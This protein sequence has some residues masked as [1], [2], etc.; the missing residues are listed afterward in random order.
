MGV[1]I[2][3]GWGAVNFL[4]LMGRRTGSGQR[5]QFR[6]IRKLFFFQGGEGDSIS[7]AFLCAG[8][9]RAFAHKNRKLK[10]KAPSGV[11]GVSKVYR[12][13]DVMVASCLHLENGG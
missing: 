10:E 11:G 8:P 2:T 9:L 12:D 5:A 3:A 6:K 7:G 1:D 13:G 4:G